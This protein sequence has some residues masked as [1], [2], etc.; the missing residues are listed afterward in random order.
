MARFIAFDWGKVR[1]GIAVSDKDGIIASPHSTVPT[2][3][4][5]SIVEQLIN[6]EPCKALVVGVP[7]LITGATTDSSDGISEF[8]NHLNAKYPYLTVHQIDESETSSEA[9]ESMIAGGLK[10]SKRREK[11]EIDKVAAALILQRFLQ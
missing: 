2:V 9:L 7:G 11:G 1:T 6:E 4:L 3:N 8:I 10:K 5:Y